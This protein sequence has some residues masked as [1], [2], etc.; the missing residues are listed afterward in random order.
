MKQEYFDTNQSLWNQKLDIHK[1]SDFYSLEAFKKG[2]FQSLRNIELE[3]LSG[4]VKGKTML[5]LQCHFG[6]DSLAWARLGA[7]VTGVD[8]SEKA[9]ALA[10]ELNDELG[11]DAKFVH[12]NVF[13]TR[14]HIQEKFDIVFTSYGTYGWLPDLKPWAKVISESLNSGGI[15]YMADFHPLLSIYDFD[16]NKMQYNYFNPN[17]P[18]LE[19][20]DSTYADRNVELKHKEY[21]WS[22]SLSEVITPLL[23]E[24]LQ[25]ELFNEYPY[26][27]WNCFSNLK[28][29]GEQQF[30]FEGF[31][32]SMPHLFE[33]KFRKP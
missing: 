10:R 17:E 27:N 19:I 30:V 24:G 18:D 26:S 32:H 9:I 8:L 1:K 33:L 7:K 4:I 20:T 28:E 2:T 29:V 12:A 13:E 21:T 6:Q 5:H 31:E 23:Q 14:Q 15:F 22:H 16:K 25:L 11:L 3:A